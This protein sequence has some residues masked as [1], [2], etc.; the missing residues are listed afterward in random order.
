MREPSPG[1]CCRCVFSAETWRCCILLLELLVRTVR[2][3]CPH[4]SCLS[5][6]ALC[7]GNTRPGVDASG[8]YARTV[9]P[10]HTH[11][12]PHARRPNGSTC[13]GASTPHRSRHRGGHAP[14]RRGEMPMTSSGGPHVAPGRFAVRAGTAGRDRRASLAP[15]AL[16][17]NSSSRNPTQ[18]DRAN[19]DSHCGPIVGSIDAPVPT[20]S[21]P[22]LAHAGT[23]A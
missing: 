3:G 23:R 15:L 2:A 6:G 7:T 1:L 16:A 11:P 22:R 5:V 10:R 8:T 19:M 20:S 9:N 12:I 18:R 17:H 21:T 4:W 13:D 14:R